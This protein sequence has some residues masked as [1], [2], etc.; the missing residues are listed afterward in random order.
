VVFDLGGVLLH[1]QPL[2]LLKQVL[3]QHASDRSGAQALAAQIFQGFDPGSDWALFDLGQIS[4][5]ALARRAFRVGGAGE[6]AAGGCG[7]VAG[8][9]DR[10][11]LPRSEM[12]HLRMRWNRLRRATRIAALR[13]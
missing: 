11:C 4:P 12:P 8:L 13:G 5:E 10:W 6:G 2:A 7:A 3:P 1:W 9:T